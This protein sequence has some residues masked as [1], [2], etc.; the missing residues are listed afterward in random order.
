MRI[1]PVLDLLRGQAVHAIKGERA[2]YQPVKSVLCNSSDPLIL[3]RAFR[4][5]LG[6][7][8]IYV[9]DLDAIQGLDTPNHRDVITALAHQEEMDVILDAGV[10]DIDGAQRWLDHGVRKVIIGSETLRDLQ[11][12][13]AI[14]GRIRREQLT[15]SLDSRSG[16]I[17]SQCASLAAMNPV[18]ALELLQESGWKEIILLDLSRVGSGSGMD[19][20]L[21]VRASARFPNLQLLVGGGMA[22][23]E[24]LVSLKSAGI[25]GV[26]VATALHAGTIGAQN[27]SRL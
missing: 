27:I 13:R 16:S 20:S 8:E 22:K 14:P 23:P 21:A 1:I 24:D 5:Q 15:F 6:M 2:Q 19:S 12:L 26:L 25:A 18:E 11:T 10:S 9:A 7:R 4:D 3:A 17:L